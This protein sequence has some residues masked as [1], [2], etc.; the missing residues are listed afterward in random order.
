VIA[1]IV[2]LLP[3]LATMALAQTSQLAFDPLEA[4]VDCGGT[5]AVD[6]TIADV[7]DLQGF[8]LYVQYDPDILTF[9]GAV[10]GA[11]LDTWCPGSTPFFEVYPPTGGMVR[12][13]GALLGCTMST[14]S[15]VDLVTLTFSPGTTKA[16]SAVSIAGMTILRNSGNQTIVYS[17]V[18]GSIANICNTAPVV[19]PASFTIPENSAGGTSVGTVDASDADASDALTFTITAGNEAGGFAINPVSGEITVA[20]PGVLD[21]ETTPSFGLQVTATDDDP[22]NPLAGSAL[23]TVDLTDVNEA[24]VVDDIPDQ[25]INEGESFTTLALDDHVVDVDNPDDEITWSYSGNTELTVTIDAARVATISIPAPDWSGSE[26]IT[27]TATDPGLLS[28]ND[29]ATFTVIGVNDPPEVVQPVD[30]ENVVGDSPSLQIE[31][32]DPESGT[33]EYAADGLPTGLT[34]DSATGLI[35]GTIACGAEDVYTVDVIVSDDGAP[36]GQTT[37]S[38][39]WTVTVLPAPAPLAAALTVD[40]VIAGNDDDGTTGISL[41]WPDLGAGYAVRVYRKGFGDYPEYDDAAGTVPDVAGIATQADAID[42]GWVLADLVTAPG[43]VDEPSLRDVWYYIAFVENIC[44]G[45]SG[46]SPLSTGVLNYHLGDVAPAGAEPPYGDN[47]VNSADVSALGWAYA[48]VPADGDYNAN[49]DVGPTETGAVT[50]RPTTDNQIEFE[51]LILFAINYGEVGKGAAAPQPSACNQLTICVPEATADGRVD[52]GLWLEADG[53]LKGASIP[54]VWNADVVRPTG[55]TSGDLA[56]AQAGQALILAP[57]PGVLD[58][59]LFGAS[60]AGLSGGGLLATVTFE[61][62]G[63]GDPSIGAGD[64]R[65]RSVTNEAVALAAVVAAGAPEQLAIP[66]VSLLYP[67]F[68][69]PFNPQTTL[70]FGVAVAGRVSLRIH[71]MRGQ[72]VA[73]LVNADR[74][75]GTYTVVWDGTDVDG[76]PVA[77][78]VYLARLQTSDRR[79]VQRMTLLK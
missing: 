45:A 41:S 46:P 27:F 74:R 29:A 33:L 71:D 25:A 13:D 60:D 53:T 65:A 35:S 6:V 44:G 70:K 11:D 7:A 38:F 49:C 47:L 21:F 66:D 14:A 5:V 69:N 64:I 68:P 32:T 12:I 8:A 31:A 48:T 72:V 58:V 63:P 52:V 20:D 51:D 55:F 67:N 61:V 36:V 62:L 2:L 57:E 54:L 16:T 23:I 19:T 15:P 42:D 1:T 3:G 75:A 56:L 18:D 24:P 78:G 17:V 50:G 79:Q 22:D 77:S 28:D 4:S 43:D 73:T 37:V 39:T 10:A 59:G 76:H 34:I 40:Q 9:D 26:T 30:Q